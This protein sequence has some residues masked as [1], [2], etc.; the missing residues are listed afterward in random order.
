MIIDLPRGHANLPVQHWSGTYERASS[1]T[2]AEGMAVLQLVREVAPGSAWLCLTNS[3]G[4]ILA[5]AQKSQSKQKHTRLGAIMREIKR[6]VR[7]KDLHITTL[8]VPGHMRDQEWKDESACKYEETLR[9][10]DLLAG[11]PARALDALIE[12]RLLANAWADAEAERATGATDTP[13]PLVVVH[14]VDQAPV[15]ERVVSERAREAV[16]DKRTHVVWRK[17]LLHLLQTHSMAHQTLLGAAPRT[18]NLSTIGC[19]RQG[20]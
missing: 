13:G 1:S 7:D 12:Y 3:M 18:R 10:I 20:S 5:A 19:G 4:L 14:G 2:E 8:W 11:T 15:S 17:L 9:G 16:L 6:H